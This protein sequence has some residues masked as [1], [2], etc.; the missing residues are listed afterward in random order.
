[1]SHLKR[2]EEMQ[3]ESRHRL[4][5]WTIWQLT[6]QP[7][8]SFS[9]VSAFDNPLCITDFKL[10]TFQI[11]KGG[12]SLGLIF[13]SFL[14]YAWKYLSSYRH[15]RIEI[16]PLS[17]VKIKQ[18]RAQISAPYFEIFNRKSLLLN[19]I[20]VFKTASDLCYRR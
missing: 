11:I 17:N 14:S 15:Q 7:H 16:G 1:M 5:I 10:E 4:I 18:K 6:S 9:A 8:L 13:F 20:Q 2:G 3:I 19:I 12:C